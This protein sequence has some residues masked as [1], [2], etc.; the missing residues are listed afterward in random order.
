MLTSAIWIKNLSENIYLHKVHINKVIYVK[1][2]DL[3]TIGSGVNIR[4]HEIIFL[5]YVGLGLMSAIMNFG[6]SQGPADEAF[7]CSF[8]T[9]SRVTVQNFIFIL[10]LSGFLGISPSLKTTGHATTCDTLFVLCSSNIRHSLTVPKTWG[11]RTQTAKITKKWSFFI[12][13][14]TLSSQSRS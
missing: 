1:F 10:I 13:L 2:H 14:S 4:V 12:N 8:L 7:F 11:G 9:C 5:A 6:C 3:S